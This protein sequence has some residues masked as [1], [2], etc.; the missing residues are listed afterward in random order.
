MRTKWNPPTPIE[1]LFEQLK[2][3]QQYMARANETI[4]SLQLV[5]W[6]LEIVT[7]TG[8]FERAC[9]DWET[10]PQS[11]RTWPAFKAFFTIAEKTRSKRTAKEAGY[12]NAMSKE[13]QT[14]FDK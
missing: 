7:D 14:R 12:A 9:E 2:K 11:T 6:G 10:K 13:S 8:L 4:D 1:N 5:R 3:G